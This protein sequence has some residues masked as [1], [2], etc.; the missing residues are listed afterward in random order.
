[1]AKSIIDMIPTDTDALFAYPLKWQVLDD[2]DV[3][4][5]KM[6]PWVQKKLIEYL[7]ATTVGSTRCFVARVQRLV[8]QAVWCVQHMLGEVQGVAG[9][10]R[11]KGRRVHD[12]QR[13][14]LRV[15]RI[16][17][18]DG[19][20]GADADGVHHDAHQAAQGAQRHS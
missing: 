20:G 5:E 10:G 16:G 3:A 8:G 15:S 18:V 4:D 14:D 11:K 2:N 1:M 6:K 19:G 12:G 17:C 7:C 13:W 9:L